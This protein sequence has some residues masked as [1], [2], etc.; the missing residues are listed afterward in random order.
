M[1]NLTRALKQAL[2]K[3]IGASRHSAIHPK[4]S[5]VYHRLFV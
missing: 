3:I 1:G 5:A 4:F 2:I